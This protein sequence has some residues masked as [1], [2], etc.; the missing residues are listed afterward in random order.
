MKEIIMCFNM[1]SNSPHV[2][3]KNFISGL[4][5]YF[6]ILFCFYMKLLD[7]D[8]PGSMV[9]FSSRTEVLTVVKSARGKVQL[10]EGCFFGKIRR[11]A[12]SFLNTQYPVL[13]YPSLFKE[14]EP[15][16][17]MRCFL[18]SELVIVGN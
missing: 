9:C 16:V 5:F 1:D 3:N 4:S 7:R 2:K 11:L 12:R 10:I 13:K 6:K 15:L 14:L 17:K 18:S 8:R